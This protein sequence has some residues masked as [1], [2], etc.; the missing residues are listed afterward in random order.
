MANKV[1]FLKMFPHYHPSE[2]FAEALSQAVLVNADIDPATRRIE[3]NMA[4][5]L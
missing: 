4:S 1:P 5:K 2:A 3:V